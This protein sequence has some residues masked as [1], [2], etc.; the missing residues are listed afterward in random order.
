[1]W[2]PDTSFPRSTLR[3]LIEPKTDRIKKDDFA[4][5]LDIVE[6]ISFAEGEI[7]F[8]KYPETGMDLLVAEK[9][10]L[11]TSKINLHQGAV[12]I[13]K[14]RFAC[15]THYQVYKINTTDAHPDYLFHVLRSQQFAELLNEQKNKGI[16]NEQGAKFL[17]GFETPLPLPDTQIRIAKSLTNIAATIASCKVIDRTFQIS[18]PIIDGVKCERLGNA[19]LETRNGWSP[20][21]DGGDLPVLTLS[22]LKNGI[23]DLSERKYTD[24]TRKD[25]DKFFVQEGDFF[26]SRGNTPELVALAG[27]ASGVSEDIVF[28]DLLTRVRL[29]E[30][31]ILP[32]YAV[33][34]FNSSLGRDY[35]GRVPLGASPSMVK[36]SQPYME[37]FPVPFMRDLQRQNEIVAQCKEAVAG[38]SGLVVVLRHAQDAQKQI[39]VELWR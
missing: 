25:I 27:L 23:L 22:C 28:P 4:G 2:S 6:K 16:K 29:D 37:E 33:V 36:V 19:V 3:D 7:T 14:R 12:A 20:K 24:A 32:E 8:R 38:V 15:S 13:A 10:D 35:F 31:L 11:I 34:L 1:M 39:M 26:F 17:L 5:E 21:C 9:G 30:A 18:F